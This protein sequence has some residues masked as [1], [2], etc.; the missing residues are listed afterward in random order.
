MGSLA[1]MS[2]AIK[3][4]Y[5]KDSRFVMDLYTL[6]YDNHESLDSLTEV[7]SIIEQIYTA[8]VFTLLEN[9]EEFMNFIM[10]N[11]VKIYLFLGVVVHKQIVFF[12]L[13]RVCPNLLTKKLTIKLN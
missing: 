1:N 8:L 12:Y 11:Q 10:K 4:H 2:K 6:T 7:V 13:N 3:R 5:K 9:C